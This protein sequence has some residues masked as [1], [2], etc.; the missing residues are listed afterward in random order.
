MNF[1]RSLAKL[2]H[3]V[4]SGQT[5]RYFLI[6]VMTICSTVALSQPG[7]AQQLGKKNNLVQITLQLPWH[8]QFQF[9]GYYAAI[10][11]NYYKDAGFNVTVKSGSPTRRSIDEVLAG[12]AD[13]GVARSELLLHRLHGEPLVALAAVFQHSAIVFLA[14]KDSKINTPQDMIG[15]KVMLLPGNDAAE[16]MAV[17]RNEGI[18][19]DQVEIIPSSFEINDLLEGKTDVFNA[20]V[21][22]EPYYLK[23]RN[24]P[25]TVIKPVT[26]GIDFY[27]DTLFT[28]EQKLNTLPNQVKKFRLASLRGWKYAM[29]H[30]DEIIDL[31]KDKYEVAKSIDHLRFE[32]D[33][34]RPLILPDLIEIGHMNPGRWRYMAETYVHLG[35]AEPNYSLDSFVYNPNPEPDLTRFYRLMWIVIVLFVLSGITML[36]YFNYRLKRI[37]RERTNELANQEIRFRETFNNINSGIAIYKAIEN[38]ND[39]IFLDLNPAGLRSSKLQKQDVLGKSVRRVFPNIVEMGLFE[40]FQRVWQT[41]VAENHPSS[42]YK[43]QRIELWVENYVYKLPSDEIVAVYDDITKRKQAEEVLE[44]SKN[45]LAKSQDIAHIGS[46]QLDRRNNLLTWS[47]EV[48]RILGLKPQEFK[49]TYE[50]FLEM[51]HPEDRTMVNSAYSDSLGKGIGGY[52]IE[53]RIIRQNTGEVRYV[54]EKCEHYRDATGSVIRSIGIVQDIT[55]LKGQEAQKIKIRRQQEELKR[56]ASLKTMAG[57]IAHRFNNSMTAVLGNLELLEMTIAADL[58]ESKNVSDALQVARKASQIGSMMLTYVGQRVLKLSTI[59]FVDLARN[60]IMEL[61]NQFLTSISLKFTSP[62]EPLY[63]L[64]DRLQMKEVVDVVLTNAIESL[65]GATGT[66]EISFGTE[67]CKTSSF[68]IPFQSDDLE[69]GLYS[70][71]QIRDTGNGIDIEDLPKIFEPFFTTK[72]VGR[73]LGLALTVGIMRAH[74]GAL[75]VESIPDQGT[76]VRILLPAI[77]G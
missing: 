50:A 68:P 33:A 54:Y 51:I 53:H 77:T 49:V 52:E 67:K 5:G 4:F 47:D 14:K 76:T 10:D 40:V 17:F 12:R 72:F 19:P 32:A 43:D 27:G 37:V 3:R 61:K 30:P 38:G 13:Y 45:L 31:L 73:G 24:I 21:T 34:M 46:W 22:N 74:H 62:P 6:I 56:L 18:A 16:Y 44:E 25:A 63:C 9:A 69:D 39:F 8:H 11:Q 35:M 59:N 15:R 36:I 28:S 2:L 7:R 20:Y 70:F 26:Y 71:C 58:P 1:T 42:L 65:E 55:E 75:T 29:A 57:A 48:Y 23:Q 66:I 60:S 64:M 41:G